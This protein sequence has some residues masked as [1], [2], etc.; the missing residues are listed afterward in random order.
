M[1]TNALD[2]GSL[3]SAVTKNLTANQEA[4]NQADTYNN[5]H[6]THIVDIFK[7][8][9]KS[10]KA[11]K[12]A[13]PAEQL[14]HASATVKATQPSGSGKFYAD[15]LAT[16]AQQLTGKNLDANTAMTLVTALLGGAQ[17]APA[18]TAQSGAGDLLGALLGGSGQ[19]QSQSG[20]GDLLGSLLGSLTGQQ[21]G[22]TSSQ[23]DGKLDINDLMTA[24]MSYMQSKSR[25]ASNTEAI[26]SAILA[27]SPLGASQDR[28]M[29]GNII[30]STLLQKLSSGFS[31]AK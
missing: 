10:V 12:N 29:S 9:T 28:A 14:A 11:N 18:Q 5:D 21:S 24:G 1:A 20:T 23:T 27:A 16:A 26:V 30:A 6:G 31:K 17:Q 13:S 8:I 3:F 4:L 19:S 22:Q 25:G 7:T 15:S 2:L